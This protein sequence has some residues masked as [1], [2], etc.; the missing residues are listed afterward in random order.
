MS[1]TFYL[2]VTVSP[3]MT[4]QRKGLKKEKLAPDNCT[5]SN[6]FALRCIAGAVTAGVKGQQVSWGQGSGGIRDF[7]S[8]AAGDTCAQL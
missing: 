2:E 5:H 8:S 7:L 6:L 3:H 1:N 4:W